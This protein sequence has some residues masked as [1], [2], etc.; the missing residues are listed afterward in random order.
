MAHLLQDHGDIAQAAQVDRAVLDKDPDDKDANYQVALQDMRAGRDDLAL[1]LLQRAAA[2]DSNDALVL[3][4][5]GVC[6]HHLGRLEQAEAALRRAVERDDR[7]A[8]FYYDLGAAYLDDPARSAEAEQAL[9]AA[10]RLAPDYSDAWYDLGVARIKLGR[11]KEALDAFR[12]TIALKPDKVEAL[13]NAAALL[14]E[15]N[16]PEEAIVLLRQALS[17]SQHP[18][19][20]NNLGEALLRQGRLSDA[21]AQFQ[22]AIDGTP[23]TP[24]NRDNLTRYLQNLSR[25]YAAM[26]DKPRADAALR[27]ARL[28]PE[29][30]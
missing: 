5:L 19:L 20:Y 24:E 25:T 23:A 7:Q 26:G 18:S 29:A 14:V 27:Q 13:N 6:Y 9:S 2:K 8:P 16:R 21:S 22:R 28:V 17:F 3:L 4:N 10:T 12:R 30:R 11:K 15:L 1:A